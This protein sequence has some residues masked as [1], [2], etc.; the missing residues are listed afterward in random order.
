MPKRF[1][2]NRKYEL[3]TIVEKIKCE[4]IDGNYND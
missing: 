4:T 1:E 2:N 3:Q